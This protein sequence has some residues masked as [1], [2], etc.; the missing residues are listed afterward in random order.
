MYKLINGLAA[1]AAAFV[2]AAPASATVMPAGAST[3]TSAVGSYY[4]NGS[5]GQF[6]V[7]SLNLAQGTS[8]ITDLTTTAR[9]W[10]QGYGGQDPNSNHVFMGLYYG[11]DQ[12]W[13]RWVA[14]AYHQITIQTFDLRN[15]MASFDQLNAALDLVD[16]SENKQLNM[17]MMASPLGYPAWRLYVDNA[18]F[19]VTSEVGAVPEPGSLALLGLG[20]LGLAAR[21]RA[22]RA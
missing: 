8:E 6:L 1:V 10:D 17:Q 20:V 4:G 16:W 15:D 18:S 12:I 19:T 5:W 22:M 2:F 7:T 11:A 13:A 21:R 3:Q 9:I 14:G